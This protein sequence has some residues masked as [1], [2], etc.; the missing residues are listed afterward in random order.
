MIHRVKSKRQ[1]KY[2]WAI[3]ITC[4]GQRIR[5]SGFNTRDEAEDAVA[6]IRLRQRSRRLGLEIAEAE[7]TLGQ[8]LKARNK[9]KAASDTRMRTV[10]L[11]S[12]IAF[13]KHAGDDLPVRS[14][15]L[16]H[17][18][19]Y[20]DTC[21][22]GR[23]ALNNKMAGVIATLNAA[24][25]YFPELEGYRAPRM[26]KFRLP[27]RS[28]LVPRKEF[29]ALLTALRTGTRAHG[30]EVAAVIEMLS[31]TGARVGEI[32]S[33]EPKQIDWERELLTIIATK[34]RTTKPTRLIPLTPRMSALLHNWQK[35]TV[36]YYTLHKVFSRTRQSLPDAGP[37]WRVHDLRHNCASLLAEAGVSHAIIAEMLG[38]ALAGVTA[39]YTHATIPALRQAALVLE[40]WCA[41][42]ASSHL[43]I[44]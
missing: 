38:H 33:L 43:K 19:R 39:R 23:A 17:L 24:P 4:D 37:R 2:V 30:P 26:T 7:I 40:R 10:M 31:L 27:G 1:K 9:D 29:Q 35:P 18:H 15:K 20:R 11:A 32:L 5:Q 21:T 13:V 41:D 34:T 3:N 25:R 14:V 28:V 44:V 12:F 6:A 8:L 42:S 36:T 22:G 16:T